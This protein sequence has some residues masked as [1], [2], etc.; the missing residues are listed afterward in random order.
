V[1]RGA[2]TVPVVTLSGCALVL[3][4]FHTIVIYLPR[5]L[6]ADECAVARCVVMADVDY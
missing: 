3:D 2:D 4:V 1:R 5:S 6:S